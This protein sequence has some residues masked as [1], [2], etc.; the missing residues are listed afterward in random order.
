MTATTPTTP[1]TRSKGLIIGGTVA[2]AAVIAGTIAALMVAFGSSSAH[3]HPAP[4]P[5]PAPAHHTVTPDQPI[6]PAH[7]S[8]PVHPITPANT[9]NQELPASQVATIQRE[10]AQLNYYEGPINGQ[11]TP[12]TVQAIEYLQRD[13]HLPQNGYYD[14]VTYL[15]LQNFLANGNN[16]MA[17]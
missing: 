17:G 6:T 12:Q 14:Q 8:K 7:P 15:A 10:L 16:Q 2:G 13:A 4:A 11:M 3:A 9:P 5:T 1:S